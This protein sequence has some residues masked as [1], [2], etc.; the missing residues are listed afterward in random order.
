MTSERRP[1]LGTAALVVLA[2]AA[3]LASGT[4]LAQAPASPAGPSP[5]GFTIG[6]RAG[7]GIP[8]GEAMSGVSLGD[9]ASGQVPL[10]LDA[11]WR[12]DPSWRL[13]VYAQ[14][15]F[16]TL[17]A[18]SCPVGADCSGQNLRFGVQAAY[19]FDAAG[20]WVGAGLGVEWQTATVST[21][22]VEN[23]LRLFGLELLNLQAGWDFRPGGA[24]SLGPFA[25]FALGQ[26]RTAT[27]GGVSENLDAALHGWVQIG[28]RGSFDL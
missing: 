10:Q 4:A 22:G 6:A 13:G 23:Q 21:A 7:Y 15:G 16:A 20:P 14:Y 5:S 1:R 27:S 26:Y 12:L 3:V 28:V 17:A 9:L 8:V 25:A 11:F 2:S 19:A 18:A 24:L